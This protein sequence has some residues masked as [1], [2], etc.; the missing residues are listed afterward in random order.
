MKKKTLT[1][2]EFLDLDIYIVY[3][4]KTW[5]CKGRDFRKEET[6]EEDRRKLE[7]SYGKKQGQRQSDYLADEF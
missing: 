2:E 6:N 3:K 7:V 5:K 4:G 1:F